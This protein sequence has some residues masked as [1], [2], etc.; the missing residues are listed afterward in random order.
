LSMPMEIS[1][2]TLMTRSFPKKNG[3][4]G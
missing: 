3:L 1:I 4:S 2:G